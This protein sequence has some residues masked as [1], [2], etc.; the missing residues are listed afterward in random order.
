MFWLLCL[1]A[2]IALLWA[3]ARF[4]L[5]GEDLSSYDVPRYDPVRRVPSPEHAAVLEK[6]RQFGADAQRQR[7]RL[8]LHGLRAA[9][10][11]LG[12]AA[13]LD[14]ISVTPVTADAIPAEWIT[15]AGGSA[16][17]RLLYLHG[18][19][20]TLG[21]A[22]SHRVLTTE[23]ARRTGLAVL[24]I[25]YR[26]MPEHPR[27]AGID[28]CRRAYRWLLANG[29]A[30]PAPV[31]RL[32]VAGDSAGG[33]L[34][35]MLI[36]WARDAG[37]RPPDGAIALSPLTDSTL[38][39]PSLSYNE[40]QD[41]MLGPM[42]RLLNRVPRPLLLWFA[43]LQ[44]RRNPSDPELSPLRGDLS[45]LPPV[46]VQASEAEILIDDARRYVNRARAQGS[47]AELETW[48]G[49]VHVW[50]IFGRELPEADEALARLAAFVERCR[51][52][53][54]TAPRARTA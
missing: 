20:F 24:A 32:F 40:H 25:D 38:A 2:L 4:R 31:R 51:Q 13:D 1:V 43:L 50:Q 35:L 30:G 49:M 16:D 15:A 45:H 26:L 29:P 22:R 3:I 5:Q 17:E 34:T 21:S 54:E 14:G 6:V 42:A 47:P 53:R 27:S 7:G 39:S 8:R 52:L 33:N 19:A 18:G 44:S 48:H 11:A 46:L 41:P 36:A 10:D 37:L 23:I 28:D 12:D 9:M